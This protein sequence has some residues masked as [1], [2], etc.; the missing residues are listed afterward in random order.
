MIIGHYHRNIWASGGIAS[1][2]SRIGAAQHTLGHTVHYFSQHLDQGASHF[3]MPHLVST[4]EDLHCQAD[5]LGLDIL[6]LHCSINP[7]LP[8]NHVVIRTLHEHSPY[9]PSGTQ[10]LGQWSKPCDRVYSLHGCLW[11]HFIDRCGSIR[12]HKLTARFQETWRE[13]S[14]LPAIPV[15]TVSNFLKQHM[16]RAGYRS[17]NI[18]VLH[19]TAPEPNVVTTPPKGRIPHFLFL[20]R[21]T[22][23]KGVVWLI[24]A[25]QLVQAPVHLD[26]AGVG[27]QEVEIH[28]LVTRLGIADRVTFHGWVSTDRAQQLLCDSRALICPS[29]WHEPGGTIAFEAMLNARAI[30]MSKVGGMPEVIHH[31]INGLLVEPND[32]IG[33]AKSIDY[34]AQDWSTAMRLGQTGYNMAIEQFMLDTHLEQL[35]KIYQQTIAQHQLIISDAKKGDTHE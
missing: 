20:G 33:L 21:I 35:H 3:P 28:R 5:Q 15:I 31:D 29:V 19:L 14:T 10:F 12:P 8:K 27:D 30:I 4:N 16:V 17:D 9:C 1:Y 22:P 32:L 2:I 7:P 24:K 13:M 34:L 26:I 25:L 18:Y 11:G 6:H 23:T